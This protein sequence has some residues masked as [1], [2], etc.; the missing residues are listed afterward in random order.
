MTK[1]VLVA[2][3]G[4]IFLSDDGFGV[5]VVRRLQDRPLPDGVTVADFGIRGVHL[6]FELMDGYDVLILV[7]AVSR[8]AEPGTLFVIEPDVASHTEGTVASVGAGARALVDA[9]GMEPGSML[10]AID[11]LEAPVERVLVVGCQPGDVSEGIGLTDVVERSIPAAMELVEDVISREVAFRS[12]SDAES[13]K[14][15]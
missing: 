6:A 7:D 11:V 3:V 5:E 13:R 10:A 8:D 1:R 15:Q 14:E 2:G 12:G 9:H 4:N